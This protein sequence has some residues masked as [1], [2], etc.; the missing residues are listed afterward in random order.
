MLMDNSNIL[1]SFYI[2]DELNP[3]VWDNPDNAKEA[4]LKEIIRKRLLEIADEFIEFLDIPIFVLDVT[5]TG[6][7]SNYNWS[8]Y[9]DFDLHI[10]YDYNEAGEKKSLLSDLFGLKKTYFNSTHDIT[11]RGYEVELYV[12]DINEPHESTG[13]YSLMF[14]KWIKEP[15]DDVNINIDKTIVLEKSQQWMDIIDNL[16][17]ELNE[18]DVEYEEGQEKISK[19]KD[20]IKKFRASGLESGGEYSY[21]NLVFKFLRRSGYIEKLYSFAD[22]FMDKKLS[23]ENKEIS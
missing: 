2:K 19:L 7:L 9:S 20:K 15:S 18:D 17:E 12:Q 10:L 16:M 21:E 14:N 3:K 5:L 22:E 6:S 8:S 1:K 11:I 13:V 23:L 4:K